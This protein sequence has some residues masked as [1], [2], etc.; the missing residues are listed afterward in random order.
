MVAA[1]AVAQIIGV[2]VLLLAVNRFVRL[3]QVAQ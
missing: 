3:S 2:T 1:V